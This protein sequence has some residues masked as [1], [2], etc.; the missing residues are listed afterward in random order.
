M[1]SVNGLALGLAT[2][3][4]GPIVWLIFKYGVVDF[5][6]QLTESEHDRDQSNRDVF[7]RKRTPESKWDSV[8]VLTCRK[9]GTVWDMHA[10][11]WRMDAYHKQLVKRNDVKS[12]RDDY[13]GCISADTFETAGLGPADD[14]PQLSLKEWRRFMLGESYR[15][16]S[17]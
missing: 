11:E 2:V 10:Y 8:S 14:I 7:A 12:A 9:C 5:W 1:E 16:L 13:S 3:I 4:A 6:R 15:F 17:Q